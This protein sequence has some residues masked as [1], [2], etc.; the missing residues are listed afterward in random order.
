MIRGASPLTNNSA[1]FRLA[2]R[3][4]SPSIP[5]LLLFAAE[6]R[7]DQY[8]SDAVVR[9]VYCIASPASMVALLNA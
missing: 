7:W 5:T 4:S 6:E 8:Q 3:V 9:R 2:R 1:S